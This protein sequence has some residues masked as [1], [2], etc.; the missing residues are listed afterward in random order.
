MMISFC[1][2]INIS[3]NSWKVVKLIF[4]ELLSFQK[5][6]CCCCLSVYSWL[7]IVPGSETTDRQCVKCL[8]FA[9][10]VVFINEGGGHTLTRC[11][12]VLQKTPKSL[13]NMFLV[14]DLLTFGFR[15]FDILLLN[16]SFVRLWQ[17]LYSCLPQKR[18]ECCVTFSSYGWEGATARPHPLRERK[19]IFTGMCQLIN[20]NL[21]LSG[22]IGPPLLGW[23]LY[24][25]VYTFQ[26]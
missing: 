9:H 4:T 3:F 17:L 23:K 1:S 15:S 14:L 21:N 12:Q 11:W 8:T 20:L 6:C 10:L 18:S 7:G 24:W 26:S 13:I 19:Q 25:N 16:A 22:G 2:A 5:C